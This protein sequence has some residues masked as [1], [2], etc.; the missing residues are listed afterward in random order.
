MTEPENLRIREEILGSLEELRLA[1]HALCDGEV[2]T[3]RLHFD[4][5]RAHLND[6]DKLLPLPYT[7][8]PRRVAAGTP[9]ADS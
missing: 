4:Y 9:L 7:A 8:E 6:A 1:H 3:A 2:R 5:G